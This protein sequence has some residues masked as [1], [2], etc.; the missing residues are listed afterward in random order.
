MLIVLFILL[1]LAVLPYARKGFPVAAGV[2][3]YLAVGVLLIF[4]LRVVVGHPLL[5]NGG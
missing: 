4:V 5:V 3:G 2:V 1:S